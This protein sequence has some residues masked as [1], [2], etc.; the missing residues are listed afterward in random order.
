MPGTDSPNKPDIVCLDPVNLVDFRTIL[1][2]LEVKSSAMM[3]S[4]IFQLC[5]Q[6]AR[7]IFSSQDMRC[8]M[9]T[10]LLHQDKLTIVLFDC[11][12]SIVFSPFNIHS[13]PDTFAWFVLGFLCAAPPYLGYN[14]SVRTGTTRNLM[15]HH[16]QL[17]IKFTLFI[18][19]QIHSCGT[20]IWLAEVGPQSDLANIHREI[21]LKDGDPVIIKTTWVD[22]SSAITEGIILSLLASKGVQGAP[23]L[24]YEDFVL[25][26]CFD[27][28]ETKVSDGNILELSKESVKDLPRESMA[29]MEGFAPRTPVH[30]LSKLWGTPITCFRSA[31][32]LLGIIIDV[33]M[34]HQQALS[35][36]DV[37]P[38]GKKVKGCFRILHCDT[39]PMNI[40][41]VPQS[42]STFPS[43]PTRGDDY[44]GL[45]FDWGFAAVDPLL[46][47]SKADVPVTE[48]TNDVIEVARLLRP[49]V[50]SHI[51]RSMDVPA[52]NTYNANFL[53]AENG[54][55]DDRTI[56]YITWLLESEDPGLGIMGTQLF[57]A[58][59]L[60]LGTEGHVPHQIHHDLE[61]ILLVLVAMCSDSPPRDALPESTFIV[62]WL[63][64]DQDDISISKTRLSI[65]TSEMRF[66]H[67]INVISPYF[68]PLEMCLRE[69]HQLMY[70]MSYDEYFKETRMHPTYK[71]MVKSLR[72]AIDQLPPDRTTHYEPSALVKAQYPPMSPEGI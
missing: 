11:G 31:R 50:P 51:N 48:V 15:F 10:S 60:L 57:I 2:I 22:N 33:L 62:K 59:E 65:F 9:V 25:Q 54:V 69:L 14:P 5:A 39:S 46:D 29:C 66:E 44:H 72:R 4:E 71:E 56:T 23:V 67:E 55:L 40:G 32:E 7:L 17:H 52:P 64:P 42:H 58:S 63:F 30:M 21:R 34:T 19:T 27:A 38:D 35:N 1:T 26:P 37:T 12:G 68:S 13:E 24:I 49:A 28:K 20:V 8:F 3:K 53:V 61:S 16:L 41:M 45:L 70:G 6:R 36:Y 18:S 47:D 43:D